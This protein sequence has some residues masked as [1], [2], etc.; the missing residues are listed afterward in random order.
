[1]KEWLLAGTVIAHFQISS[2]ISANGIGEVYRATDISSKSSGLEL[3]LK[4][5]PASL[6]EDPQTRQRFIQTFSSIAQMR[7]PNGPSAVLRLIGA[8]SERGRDS[9]A[10]AGDHGFQGRRFSS[11]W[12][13]S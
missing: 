1:M 11:R 8:R 5:L 10:A 7:H 4:L 2:R 12:P 3:A 6:L 13:L 9:G